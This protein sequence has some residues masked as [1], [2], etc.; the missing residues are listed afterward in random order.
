[1]AGAIKANVSV[2]DQAYGMPSGRCDDSV[3]TGYAGQFYCAL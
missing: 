3:Y 1:M 2:I